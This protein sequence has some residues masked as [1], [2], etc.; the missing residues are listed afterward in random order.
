MKIN[1]EKVRKCEKERE[2]EKGEYANWERKKVKVNV[3]REK[4]NASLDLYTPWYVDGY[5]CRLIS[6]KYTTH[7]SVSRVILSKWEGCG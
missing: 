2:Y 7:K 5:R 1:V 6:V 3:W 4:V